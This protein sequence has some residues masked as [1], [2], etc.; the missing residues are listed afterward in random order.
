L[1]SRPVLAPKDWEFHTGKVT[2]FHVNIRIQSNKIKLDVVHKKIATQPKTL[3]VLIIA[4]FRKVDGISSFDI[5]LVKRAKQ[6]FI[7]I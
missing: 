6:G 4:E 3:R 7:N 2:E 1:Y 5:V